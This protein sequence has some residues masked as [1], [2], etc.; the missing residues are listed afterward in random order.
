MTD[1]RAFSVSF[2]KESFDEL[3]KC[4]RVQ[5]EMS[6]TEFVQGMQASIFFIDPDPFDPFQNR[7]AAWLTNF[8]AKSLYKTWSAR[9]KE[10]TMTEQTY[11]IV[12]TLEVELRRVLN[13]PAVK[14]QGQDGDGTP[15]RGKDGDDAEKQ[16]KKDKKAKTDK[17]DK[18]G[19]KK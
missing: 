18:K 5:T 19:K 2:T 6:F 15:K 1:S 16:E 13:M 7:F 10:P 3:I 11:K 17:K 8:C 14:G 12:N 4:L 9:I